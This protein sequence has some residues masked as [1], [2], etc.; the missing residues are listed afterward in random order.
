[1]FGDALGDPIAD[2]ILRA[3]RQ[4]GDAGMTRTQI[5]DLFGRNVGVNRME[6]AL[7]TLARCGKAKMVFSSTGGRPAEIWKAA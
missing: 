2:E 3:L 4:A 6:M 7:S 1:L 5:R